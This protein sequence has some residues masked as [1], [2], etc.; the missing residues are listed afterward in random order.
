METEIELS[1]LM[2]PELITFNLQATSKEAA[3]TELAQKIKA[4]QRITDLDRYL[5]AVFK[6]EEEYTTGIGKGVAI[7]H[8][9][10]AAVLKSSLAFGRSNQGITYNSMDQKP[11]YLLFLIAVPLN[12]SNEHLR[13]LSQI[14]RKLMHETNRQA[15][16]RAQS[17]EE[18]YQIFER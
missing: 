14:S 7:P 3:I 5:K 4:A 10:S 6:R 11:V 15:I 8:G 13:I 18:L 2:A 17:P 12:S 9:K 1:K 16:L